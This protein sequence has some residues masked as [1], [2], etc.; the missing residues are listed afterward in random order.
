MVIGASSKGR[1]QD[2]REMDGRARENRGPRLIEGSGTY[3][4]WSDHQ[5]DVG[6]VHQGRSRYP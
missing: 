3:I 5:Q 1:E 6:N 2:Q 4:A